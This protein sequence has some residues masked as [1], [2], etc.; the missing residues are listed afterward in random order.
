GPE[1]VIRQPAA[2]WDTMDQWCK[3]HHGKSG[4]WQKVVD[5]KIELAEAERLTLDFIKQHTGPKVSPLCGNSI[6]QDRRF[7]ARYMKSLEGYLHYRLVD[8]STVKELA[9]RWYPT[10]KFGK[11]K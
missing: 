7:L 6:W 1:L 3:E 5:S 10:Q 11:K 9:A 2:L 8:V 4:L